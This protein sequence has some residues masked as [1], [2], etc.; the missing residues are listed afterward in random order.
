MPTYCKAPNCRKNGSYGNQKDKIILYCVDHKQFDHVDVKH[1]KCEFLE[2]TKRCHYGDEKDKIIRYCI[3]HKQ[4]HHIDL[5]NKKRS[6]FNNKSYYGI[7][8]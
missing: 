5:T 6:R 3:N 1:K 7:H 4:P 2:C 8:T